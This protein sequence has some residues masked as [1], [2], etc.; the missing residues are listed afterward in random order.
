MLLSG[1]L[2][3]LTHLYHTRENEWRVDIQTNTF[4]EIPEHYLHAVY[5]AELTKGGLL[6]SIYLI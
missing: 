4:V 2:V 5:F 3:V 6:L 1:G